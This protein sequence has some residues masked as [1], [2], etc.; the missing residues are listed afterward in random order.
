MEHPRR[1]LYLKRREERRVRAGHPWVF[2]N[3]VDV[4]RSPLGAFEPGELADLR[5]AGDRWLG[6]AYV[7]PRSLICARVMCRARDQELDRALLVGRLRQALSLRERLFD[8]PWYRLVFGEG[9]ALPGLVADRYDD[10]VVLQLA[11][12]GMEARLDQVVA[13]VDE[14]LSPRTVVLRND[15][16]ARSLEGLERYVRVAAGGSPDP[17]T[18]EE[19]G[20][21]FEV[22]TCE[23]QKTGWFFDHRAN[24]DRFARY[25]SGLRVLDVFSYV[26]AFG[27]RAA[28]A[29]AASVLCVDGSESALERV[30]ANAALNESAERVTTLRGDAFEVLRDLHAGGERF[31]AVALDPPA[32]VRRKRDLEAGLEAYRRL[33]RLALALLTPGGV[34]MSASC[35]S[36]LSRDRFADTLRRAAARSGVDVQI[37]EEGHQAP[38]HPV[39]PAIPETSYLK[40]FFLRRLCG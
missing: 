24:R 22:S 37:V 15:V 21:R 31:D 36:H 8:R 5:T 13:A 40:A 10:V 32:F 34:L 28:R 17:V 7:N 18:V 4:E 39:H 25:A 16:H 26:G 6:L 23:G 3:E 14:V 33:N 27:V 38:D 19:E 35:S 1:P 29:G 9:D 2:S 12:A 30:V 20:A 11:T